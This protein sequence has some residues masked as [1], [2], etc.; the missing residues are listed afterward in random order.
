[1]L[2]LENKFPG[3][4]FTGVPGIGKSIFLIYFLSRYIFDKRFPDKRFA[5]EFKSGHYHYFRPVGNGKYYCSFD[6]PVKDFPLRDILVMSDIVAQE[7]PGYRSKWSLVFS[8]PDPRRFKQFKK[9]HNTYTYTM[10]TWSEQELEAVESDKSQW[11]DRFVKCGGVPRLVLGKHNTLR[12]M[13]LW[14][15]L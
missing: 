13:I 14:I 1:M 2:K 4:I 5:C 3:F 10:P 9:C 11:Y 7:E 15:L 8:S 6:V 12:M